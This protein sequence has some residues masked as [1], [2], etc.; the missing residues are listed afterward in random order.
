MKIVV[1]Q[2]L[3]VSLNFNGKKYFTSQYKENG[4]ELLLSKSPNA[5]S[6]LPEK[7]NISAKYAVTKFA[8]S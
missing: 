3:S 6:S 4:M 5:Y 1:A 2:D 7:L 8:T